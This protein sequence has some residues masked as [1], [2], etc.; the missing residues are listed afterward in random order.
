MMYASLPRQQFKT[1]KNMKTIIHIIIQTVLIVSLFAPA[2][3]KQEEH[4][5][6]EF[7]I[8]FAT[9]VP[10]GQEHMQEFP[11]PEEGN[12]KLEKLESLGHTLMH[13]FTIIMEKC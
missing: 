2:L 12:L 11:S 10:A 13:W 1:P 5:T 4:L 6:G 7:R 8:P 3:Y 9:P